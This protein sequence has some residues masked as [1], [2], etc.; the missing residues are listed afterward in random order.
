[1]SASGAPTLFAGGFTITGD[2][3]LTSGTPAQG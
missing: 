3:L 2:L 1:M